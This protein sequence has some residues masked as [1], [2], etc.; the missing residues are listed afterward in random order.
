[1]G[2]TGGVTPGVARVA[3]PVRFRGLAFHVTRPGRLR[4]RLRPFVKPLT[5]PRSEAMPAWTK[6]AARG[7]QTHREGGS[8]G[9]RQPTARRRQ[10]GTTRRREFTRRAACTDDGDHGESTQVSVRDK[11]QRLAC[12]GVPLRSVWRHATEG[13]SWRPSPEQRRS[14]G[15]LFY[16]DLPPTARESPTRRPRSLIGRSIR[17]RATTP[18]TL[19]GRPTPRQ[20][21]E[22]DPLKRPV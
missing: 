4:A 17:P 8:G 22:R 10:R 21:R 9:A 15:G 20:A 18:R 19:T 1:V 7:C 5:G 2:G 3:P 12:D 13:R 16:G 6:R 11:V 14:T